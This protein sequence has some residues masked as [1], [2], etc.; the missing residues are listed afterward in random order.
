MLED[1]DQCDMEGSDDHECV[2]TVND[3]HKTKDASERRRLMSIKLGNY[4]D[5]ISKGQIGNSKIP[6][7]HY[8]VELN[9]GY[10]PKGL[11]DCFDRLM[12]LDEKERIIE[13][14]VSVVV[15]LKDKLSDTKAPTR[16]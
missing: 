13:I 12:V 4:A 7:R 16:K 5:A 10:D 9:C 6:R 11:Y 2:F 14:P 8:R 3:Y 15:R 1:V